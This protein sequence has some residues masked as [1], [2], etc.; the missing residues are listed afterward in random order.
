M[1]QR[2]RRSPARFLAPL[3]LASV[4][5]ALLL[6]VSAS[7]G[8]GKTGSKDAGTAQT[9]S[10]ASQGK[11]STTTV[12]SGTGQAGTGGARSYRVRV[13]DTLGG[14]AAKTGVPL[15]TLQSL[16]PNVDPQAMTAGQKIKLK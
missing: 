4:V 8:G 1:N 16:N 5:I 9:N 11:P 14:I 6:I 12:K 10:T 3:A 13:G 15:A 2:T 7:G